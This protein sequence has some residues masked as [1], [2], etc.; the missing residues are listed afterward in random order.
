MS[1][2]IPEIFAVANRQHKNEGFRQVREYNIATI[3]KGK[4][5]D[6]VQCGQCESACPQ[7][8]GIID[9]LKQCAEHFEK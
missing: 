2:P 1:I 3:G 9:Y 6:C 8:L 5:S 7:H 4:A